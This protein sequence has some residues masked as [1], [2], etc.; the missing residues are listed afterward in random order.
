MNKNRGPSPITTEVPR[1]D[2]SVSETPNHAA[3]FG[4]LDNQHAEIETE[5]SAPSKL[6]KGWMKFAGEHC[7]ELMGSASVNTNAAQQQTEDDGTLKFNIYGIYLSI[8][9]YAL[10]KYFS[11]GTKPNLAAVYALLMF[12]LIL[13][14]I[15]YIAGEIVKRNQNL[16]HNERQ[17]IL[18]CIRKKNSNIAQ[19][20][21][22]LMLGTAFSMLFY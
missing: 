17:I 12:Q 6:V 22:G 13:V 8:A 19:L 11:L 9:Y 5:K 4:S 15:E 14:A 3:P 10:A 18:K 7:H 2:D 21:I 16:F 20:L 1:S